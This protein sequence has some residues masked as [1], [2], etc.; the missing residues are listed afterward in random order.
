MSSSSVRREPKSRLVKLQI[1]RDG[2]GRH[3][4]E[5]VQD[6]EVQACLLT[7][8]RLSQVHLYVRAHLPPQ[9]VSVGDQGSPGEEEAFRS[10]KASPWMRYNFPCETGTNICASHVRIS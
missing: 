4:N 9:A 8:Q 7:S 5:W 2:V 6:T 1:S 10:A 3:A